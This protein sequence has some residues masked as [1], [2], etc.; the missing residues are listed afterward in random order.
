MRDLQGKCIHTFKHGFRNI[1]RYITVSTDNL[2]MVVGS[3]RSVMVWDLIKKVCVNSY[4]HKC[5]IRNAEF[6]V[7][8]KFLIIKTLNRIVYLWNLQNKSLKK[9]DGHDLCT[10]ANPDGKTILSDFEN[11]DV[12]NCIKIYNYE[13]ILVK[14]IFIN[15]ISNVAYSNDG[16]LLLIRHSHYGKL[17]IIDLCSD[18]R[19][20]IDSNLMIYDNM[21]TRSGNILCIKNDEDIYY[22]Y[23]T[24]KFYNSQKITFCTGMKDENSVLNKSFVKNDLY[25]YHLPKEIFKYLC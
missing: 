8:N 7:D 24:N 5:F 15:D 9:F 18:K 21:I 13:K 6:T 20:I 3:G 23:H 25:D 1:I 16:K 19:Q 10:I 17:T 14:E 22:F 4:N 12:L 2:L 11:Y